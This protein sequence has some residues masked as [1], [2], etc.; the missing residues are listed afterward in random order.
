MEYERAGKCIDKRGVGDGTGKREKI[1]ARTTCILVLHALF[2]DYVTVFLQ[3]DQYLYTKKHTKKITLCL[4]LWKK[5][6]LLYNT[7]LPSS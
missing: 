5:K 4:L 3:H 2:I 1:R 7:I 6:D